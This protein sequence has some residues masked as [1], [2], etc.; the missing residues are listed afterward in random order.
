M[1]SFLQYITEI[2]EVPE[3][4]PENH[5]DYEFIPPP[6][7]DKTQGYHMY[8][9]I[10]EDGDNKH[11]VVFT[12]IDLGKGLHKISWNLNNSFVNKPNKKYPLHVAAAIGNKINEYFH[13][14]MITRKPEKII[15]E[16]D[17]PVKDRIYQEMISKYGLT[18][19]NVGSD[20]PDMD[21]DKDENRY[22]WMRTLADRDE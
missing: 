14:H 20:P 5:P 3:Q 1:K 8:R 13:H 16:T 10:I 2:F 6:S 7:S 11:E 22:Y 17:D 19:T 9:S 21:P 18:A 12:G 4:V 15:Y